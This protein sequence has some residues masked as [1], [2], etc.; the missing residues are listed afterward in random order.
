MH[1]SHGW[2]CIWISYCCFCVARLRVPIGCTTELNHLG[3]E[4]LQRLFD[5]YDEVSISTNCLIWLN[6]PLDAKF[7]WGIFA[8][9]YLV[10]KKRSA[11]HLRTKT[12]P[13]HQLSLGTCFASVLTCH[14]VQ[15][16]TWLS[17]RQTRATSLTMVTVVSGRKY[18]TLSMNCVHFSAF[19]IRDVYPALFK[20]LHM[21]V[22]C[23]P[24]HPSLPGAPWIPRLP[25]PNWAGV[26]DFRSHRCV[27]VR[28]KNKETVNCRKSQIW[29]SSIYR[30]RFLS[31][32]SNMVS[33]KW[34]RGLSWFHLWASP[35]LHHTCCPISTMKPW[36]VKSM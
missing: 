6:V 11:S 25:Y 21:Q 23:I 27:C 4:F 36:R 34:A 19:N 30:D 18:L 12:L 3:Y 1:N 20:C 2:L 17:Q 5:K 24:W 32:E 16:S 31:K 33:I 7:L 35:L 9:C 8:H 10:L 28:E 29:K 14:G 13:C 22:F 26:T 15:R